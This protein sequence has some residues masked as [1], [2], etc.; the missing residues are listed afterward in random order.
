MERTPFWVELGGLRP[1]VQEHLLGY[2]LRQMLVFQQ[3]QHEPEDSFAVSVIQ[4]IQTFQVSLCQQDDELIVGHL[5]VRHSHPRN[6]V[7]R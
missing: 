2:L 4:D 3:I 6:T 5:F 1:N 7:E